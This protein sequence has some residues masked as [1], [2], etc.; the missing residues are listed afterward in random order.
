[1]VVAV[2]EQVGRVAVV[3]VALALLVPMEAT[4]VLSHLVVMVALEQPRL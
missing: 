4:T 2:R 1:M 3:V